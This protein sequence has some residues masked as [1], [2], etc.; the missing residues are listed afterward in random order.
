MGDFGLAKIL[1]EPAGSDRTASD[2]LVGT[3]AYMAPEQARRD[4]AGI[5]AATDIYG[6]GT[7]LYELLTGRRPFSGQRHADLL[8]HILNVEPSP[9]RSLR[10]EIPVELDTICRK[11]LE[12]KPG[13]R[14]A[15]AADL[16]DDL[17][18]WLA[19]EPISAR[20][21]PIW[22]KARSW[23]RRHPVGVG[24]MA[25]AVMALV[26]GSLLAESK[27]RQDA[28]SWLDRLEAANLSGLPALIAERRPDDPRVSGKLHA[29]FASGPDHKKL[30]A[31]V[32]LASRRPEC[33]SHAFD[34]LLSVEP[35]S[36]K[37]LCEALRLRMPD[38]PD[39]LKATLAAAIPPGAT[40]SDREANDRR[41]ARAA[42]CLVH[43]GWPDPARDLL[44][45]RPDPQARSFLIHELG[46]A[47]VDP[48]ALFDQLR[49][50][51]DPSLRRPDPEPRRSPRRRME[52]CASPPGP[53]SPALDLS[54]RPR[55]GRPRLGEVGVDEV[56]ARSLD[57]RDRR[58]AGD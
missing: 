40:E 52:H 18:S 28:A 54:H 14:Y 1:D 9:P 10:P 35:P 12:K 30:A 2:A 45:F 41:R 4:P 39:R 55:R 50:E 49:G 5:S 16:A 34:R 11:C 46:P 36:V 38:L 44:R 21:A 25:L 48:R 20:P 56:E 29:L 19:D 57:G 3:L 27:A 53:R 31:A 32:A 22:K 43:L 8:D 37:P 24:M 13:D 6:L 23:S 47:G 17:R 51:P 33:A 15:T 42:A 58:R 7:I 26:G